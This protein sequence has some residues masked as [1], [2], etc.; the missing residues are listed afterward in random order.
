MELPAYFRYWGKARITDDATSPYHLLPY[1]CL[2][3][4]A[5]GWLL[6]EPE[7]ALCQRLARQLKV[8]PGWLQAWFSFCLTLHDLG[9]FARA[10]QNLV[11]D[12]SPRLVPYRG[13]CAYSMRHDS[14]GFL[15]WKNQLGKLLSA[16]ALTVKIPEDW[17]EI[18]CG[19]HGQPPI[20]APKGWQSHFLAEDEQ[21]AESY[22]RDLIAWWQPDLTP[23]AAIDKQALRSASWQLAG[24]AVMADW[25]GSNQDIFSY[26][27]EPMPLD[28]YWQ[29][30]ALAQAPQAVA[31]SAWSQPEIAPFRSIQQQFPFISQATPLQQYAVEQPLAVGPQL[32]I[33]EDVTGAGKTEAAMVLSQRLMSAG[34]A[35]GLY[36]ALPTMATSN[37]M[38]ARL[39]KSYRALFSA[40]FNPSLVL[41]HGAAKLSDGFVAT[42]ALT[43]QGADLNYLND[44]H[45]ASAYCNAWL[46]D[47]RKKTLLAD[48]GVGTIDQV[49]LA[50]LPAR[51]QSLRLLGLSNKVLLVDEVHAY[52]PYMRRLLT[53]LLEAHARQ[54]G[55]AILLSA[56]LPQNFRQEL[57][58]SFGSGLASVPAVLQSQD[59]PLASHFAA[60][61]LQEQIIETRAQVRRHVAV[62]RLEDEAQAL[63]LIEQS[64]TAGRS[65]CWI[66]STVRDARSAFEQLAAEP[67]LEATKLTLFHSRFAMLDRQRIEAVVLARFG[68]DSGHE[69]RCGQVLIATQV[70]EQ[71][72]DLDFDLLITDLAPVDLLIQRAGRLQRHSRDRQ[73]NRL[74]ADEALD[75]RPAPCLY[76]LAPDPARVE[77]AGWLKDLL[78]GTQAVYEDVG[79]LWLSARALLQAEGFDMPEDA[80]QLIEGVYGDAA[81]EQIPELLEDATWQ[82][83]GTRRSEQGMGE[84]NRLRLEKGYTLSSAEAS[85]GW[86]EEVHI[87]TRLSADSV[88]VT[89]AQ[90]RDGAL[91]PYASGVRHDWAMSQLSLPK[92]EWDKVSQ[93][94]PVCWHA[95]IEQLIKDEPA[96]R[97]CE[98]LPLVGELEQLYHPDGGWDLNRGEQE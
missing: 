14:L 33:L 4:A 1:H 29:E 26:Q 74:D 45:S 50:V 15:F 31:C 94:I 2:D 13:Q 28:H 11:P 55:C 8:K 10:F 69:Q 5:V 61:G 35:K 6:L 92:H 83:Q 58:Q 90:I 80:R 52:D 81:Q 9:K 47:S 64:V 89:L 18:V 96:L 37:A 97:W 53:A 19:H 23:L 95:A 62:V 87:P 70:V 57:V 30:V 17:L 82:A 48:V 39:A 67:W 75:Q 42:V 38:Y 32:F 34:L 20:R 71:S 85:G 56:T 44:E 72:L 66:R 24:V 22:V 73:G 40:D 46:A 7:N 51:H 77:S 68:K 78:P 41:A 3:V 91:H 43:Q 79:Q 25:L 88:T 49:L 27:S 98:V 36:V 93:R 16:D 54:G 65:I 21:A 76:L 59:Y 60:S 86:D 84:F 12:L 63:A